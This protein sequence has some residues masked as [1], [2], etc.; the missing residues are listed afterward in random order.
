MGTAGSVNTYFTLN[1]SQT[2]HYC[3]LCTDYF[4]GDGLTAYNNAKSARNSCCYTATPESSLQ[5]SE[6]TEVTDPDTL[7]VDREVLKDIIRR[8]SGKLALNAGVIRPGL[9]RVGD[10]VSLVRPGSH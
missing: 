2:N 8:F 7:E 3:N 1:S 10:P 5:C 4:S 6:T 9:V